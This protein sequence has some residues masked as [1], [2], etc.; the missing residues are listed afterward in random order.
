MRRLKGSLRK[1]RSARAGAGPRTARAVSAGAPRASTRSTERGQEAARR[2]TSLTSA[3]KTAPLCCSAQSLFLALRDISPRSNSSVAY[4][5][6]RPFVELRVQDRIY[7]CAPDTPC[8][9][10]SLSIAGR[11]QSRAGRSIPWTRSCPMFIKRTAALESQIVVS[12]LVRQG[13]DMSDSV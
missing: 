13:A 4:G 3:F 9:F 1:A 5:A 7:Q 12:K 2:A 6:K 11:E 8:Q 10:R